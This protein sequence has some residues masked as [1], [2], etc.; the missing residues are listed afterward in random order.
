M[1]SVIL[2]TITLINIVL[3]IV[4]FRLLRTKYSDNH[5]K[6][7]RKEVNLLVTDIDRAAERDIALLENRIN[8]LRELIDEAEKKITLAKSVEENR[9]KGKAVLD[10]LSEKTYRA[11][12]YINGTRANP[13][14]RAAKMY[15]QNAAPSIL[16]VKPKDKNPVEEKPSVFVNF[17][18]DA[19]EDYFAPP[20]SF[21]PDTTSQSIKAKILEMSN[22]GFSADMIADHLHVSMTE[23]NMIIEMF[24]RY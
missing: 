8:N 22:E 6:E 19:G 9:K 12:N 15:E 21:A 18:P 3:W 13:V 23:V 5:L 1:E 16:E 7:L 14:S 2:V 4:F 10:E 11:N 17:S 24:G 20:S